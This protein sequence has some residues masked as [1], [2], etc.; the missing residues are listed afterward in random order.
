MTEH[1]DIQE[2]GLKLGE[3][4]PRVPES[5]ERVVGA[6]VMGLLCLI[7]FAN[8][9]IRYFTN[10]SFAFT[11]ELSVAL[12]VVVALVG[13]SAA[14][15][16]NRHIRLTF[17]VERL[18]VEWQRQ[19]ELV[20]MLACFGLFALLTWLSASYVWD[21]YRFDVMSPGLGIPQ[22]RYT[23]ALP[24]LSFIISLRILGR[25]GRVWRTTRRVNS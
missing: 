6:A 25:L 3:Q 24:V 2:P 23:V 16:T 4:A 17:L 15:A 7:T 13:A 21:E 14:F 5:I 18:P 20:I 11:E 10:V 19:L 1:A 9:V 8:V 22:W 12:M